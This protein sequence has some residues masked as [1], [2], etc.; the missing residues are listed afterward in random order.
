MRWV[1]TSQ[2]G[3]TNQVFLARA[4]QSWPSPQGR[5]MSTRASMVSTHRLRSS[6]CVDIRVSGTLASRS[7]SRGTLA[8]GSSRGSSGGAFGGAAVHDWAS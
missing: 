5:R 2:Q 4:E 7:S 8:S 6:A 1:T 3:L